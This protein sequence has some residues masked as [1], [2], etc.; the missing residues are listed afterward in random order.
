MAEAEFSRINA[1]TRKVAGLSEVLKV[2]KEFKLHQNSSKAQMGFEWDCW[3]TTNRRK[4]PPRKR[5]E[6]KQN[7]P[8]Q[9]GPHY[10]VKPKVVPMC[11]WG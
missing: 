3:P 11:L 7:L 10:G 4:E 2:P 1:T 8:H 5:R 9:K 6:L